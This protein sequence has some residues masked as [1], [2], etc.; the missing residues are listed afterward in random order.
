MRHPSPA[1]VVVG[2]AEQVATAPQPASPP[3]SRLTLSMQSSLDGFV[4]ETPPDRLWQLWDWGP[5]CPWDDALQRAFNDDLSTLTDVILSRRMA[6]EGYIDH[7]SR[8]A[9]IRVDDPA[10]RFAA[11]IQRARKTL[12]SRNPSQGPDPRARW[13]R[14]SVGVGALEDVVAS[15]KSS[16]EG[17]VF[18]FGGVR[19]ATALLSLGAVD[20]FHCYVNPAPAG[21]GQRLPLSSGPCAM[22]LRDVVAY[23]CGVSVR[24][25]L[26]RPGKHEPQR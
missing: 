2:A 4:G 12:I 3:M 8:M 26:P 7:W 14:T 20:E 25:Y 23:S 16:A 1:V 9:R 22:E 17:A 13:P 19:L 6:D 21:A 24:R 11:L 10:Y 5:S 15:V 18:V